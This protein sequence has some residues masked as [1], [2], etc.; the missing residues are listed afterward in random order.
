M[1]NLKNNLQ[2]LSKDLKALAKKTDSLIAAVDHLEK[3]KTAEKLQFKPAKT[4]TAKK[5]PA[6]KAAATRTGPITAADIVLGII[7]VANKSVNT[8][9]LMKKTRFTE[10]KIANLIYKL[11]KQG[12]IKSAGKG[13]YV[14]A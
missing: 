1:K 9:T 10:K 12:K 3:S 8:A 4:K 7:D 14:K 13:I 11:K 5:A 6:R 2:S